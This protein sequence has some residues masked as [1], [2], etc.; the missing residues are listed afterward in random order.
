MGNVLFWAQNGAILEIVHAILG[1][2][3]SPVG[4]TAL[5]VMSR[6][7]LVNLVAV[8]PST[9]A[10]W[11]SQWMYGAWA[12]VEGRSLLLLCA[13]LNQQRHH[14]VL[15]HLDSL[16]DLHLRLSGRRVWRAR[17]PVRL[18]PVHT[19]HAR[20]CGLLWRNAAHVIV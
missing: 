12:L 4:T 3:P 10:H 13:R 17:L 20:R 9:Q 6:V 7:V 2:V 8:S 19:S 15:P 14:S 16:L 18:A 5:Q 1:I 11:I